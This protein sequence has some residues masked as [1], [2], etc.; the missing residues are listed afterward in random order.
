MR[1]IPNRH[2]GHRGPWAAPPLQKA[3][4]LT[5]SAQSQRI[6]GATCPGSLHAELIYTSSCKHARTD[7]KSFCR[8]ARSRATSA[9]LIRA[10]FVS[11]ASA[12]TVSRLLLNHLRACQLHRRVFSLFPLLKCHG[13]F[14][15]CRRTVRSW[16]RRN[17]NDAKIWKQFPKVTHNENH[18]DGN[19]NQIDEP[20]GPEV[21]LLVCVLDQTHCEGES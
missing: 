17:G 18:T 13:T 3:G 4:G 21:L 20:V 2:T 10:V 19:E 16:T 1:T 14:P 15:I 9:C 12:E 8:K 5:C 11:S 7:F 6:K